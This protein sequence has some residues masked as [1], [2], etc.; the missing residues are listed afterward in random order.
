MRLRRPD[1]GT[2]VGSARHGG[3]RRW[4]KRVLAGLTSLFL[5]LTAVSCTTDPGAQVEF[6][7]IVLPVKFSW[8]QSGVSVTGEKNIVTPIG[9]FS[10]GAKYALPEKSSDTI[11]VIIRDR[12]QGAT[13][14]DHTYQVRSGQ[15][16]FTAV[17][18]GTTAIQ[19]VDRQVLI[20]VTDGNVQHIE[21]KSVEPPVAEQRDDFFAGIAD[22]WN[23]Y[24]AESFYTPFALFE[25]AYDD[26][27]MSK[28]FGI[29]FLWFLL[30]LTLALLLL[31]PDLLLTGFVLIAGAAFI[32]IGTAARNIVYGL[33][34]LLLLILVGLFWSGL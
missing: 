24:W 26:S 8:D 1:V 27:T 3:L 19:V 31:I 32:F 20:D 12:K 10:V 33:G 28:W 5:S 30:R 21:F 4:G 14:F 16:E 9:V 22:R 11:Y 7:P 18:N 2:M 25:W 15:G 13:G 6:R 29:G 34:A 23:T 17:V